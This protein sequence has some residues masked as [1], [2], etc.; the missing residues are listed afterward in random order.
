MELKYYLLMLAVGFFL[1]YIFRAFVNKSLKEYE[2]WTVSSIIEKIGEE[3]DTKPSKRI[4]CKYETKCRRIF[5]NIFK[6]DFPK[7]RPSFMINDKTGKRLE[8]DGYNEKLKLAFEY[9]GQQHYNFSPYFHKSQEDFA[10][11]TYR[12]KRKKELCKQHDIT[13]IEIPYNIEYND[14][15]DYIRMKLYDEGFY[16]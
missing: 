4:M 11:Q 3:K 2:P 16:A 8:L 9:Q 7:V 1:L 12:D 5:E 6:T 10:K 15:E 14:L 13:L